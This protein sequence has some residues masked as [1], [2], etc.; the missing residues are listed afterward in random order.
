MEETTQAVVPSDEGKEFIG[1]REV[2]KFDACD[3]GEFVEVEFAD[4]FK[5]KMSGT[6]FYHLKRDERG[7]GS[8][9]DN[10]NHY[11]AK[12]FLAE[13]AL[14]G[15]EYYFVNNVAT[16]MGVLAHN[17]REEAIKEAFQCS[18]GDAIPLTKLIP[19]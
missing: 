8:V 18:G 16:A 19:R 13:L 2:V 3:G 17:L 7:Q 1:D 14:N 12:R 15:L 9:T 10:V 4:G 6:L 11:F 5:T